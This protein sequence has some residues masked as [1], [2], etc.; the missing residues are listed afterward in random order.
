M[1]NIA[2]SG[3]GEIN[4]STDHKNLNL[5]QLHLDVVFGRSHG[6]IIWQPRIGAWFADRNFRNEEYPEPFRG[7]TYPPDVYRKL[8][9]S[10]RVYDYNACFIRVDPPRVVRSEEAVDAFRT[11]HT[12]ATP[13]GSLIMI[14]R[15]SPTSRRAYQE[16]Y[17]IETPEDMK[18]YTWLLDHS[19]WRWDQTVFD[20]V[21]GHWGNLGAPTMYIPRVN[22]QN[23]YIETMG[24]E[25][26]VYALYEWGGVVDDYFRVLHENHVRMIE[27]INR[28][29]IL[30]VNYGDNLHCAT[31]PPAWYERY[32]QPAYLDR[33]V[34]LHRAGRWVNSH[35][36]GDTKALLRYARVSGLDGIEAITPKP[37]GDV[38]LE[39]I[40]EALGDEI[41]LLDGIPA[42]YFDTTFS[43]DELC[44]CAEKIINL[45]APKL[46]LGISDEISSTGDLQ[47]IRTVGKIVD[48]YNAGQA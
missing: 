48:D 33:S 22:V 24:V 9:C 14:T 3:A 4:R 41:H 46:I 19:D 26:G 13:V 42:V 1:N 35:W 10:N 17:W 30:I 43:E 28:S 8:E 25:R 37:Q 40:K 15:R 16:K 5:A 36:D 12:I 38:T 44:A 39:E 29:P 31:L 20:D 32:V 27:V 21:K 11:R 45:F 47:R 34:R 23:L 7:M 6:M 2:L 18:V